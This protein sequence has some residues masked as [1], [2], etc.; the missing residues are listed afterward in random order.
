[1]KRLTI[2][3]VT[4]SFNDSY[5]VISIDPKVLAIAIAN[6]GEYAQDL[7]SHLRDELGKELFDSIVEEKC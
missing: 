2:P 3:T 5:M 6:N 7:I 4:T 1:M